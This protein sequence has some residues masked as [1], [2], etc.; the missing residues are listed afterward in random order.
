MM[1][2]LA[3]QSQLKPL[4]FTVINI[5]QQMKFAV[6]MNILQVTRKAFGIKSLKF[7]SLDKSKNTLDKIKVPKSITITK[8]KSK[9]L[10]IQ[11]PSN[12]KRVKKFTKKQGQVKVSITYSK[13]TAKHFGFYYDTKK[14][15][16]DTIKATEKGT[17]Y[18]YTTVTLPNGDK[19]VFATKVIVK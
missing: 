16:K 13:E 7:V 6:R 18:A 19:K 2:L 1:S 3:L 15:S 10:S 4:P 11:L 8:G 5:L 17:G 12:L 14:V 9:K